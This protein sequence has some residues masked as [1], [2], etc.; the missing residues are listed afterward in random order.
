VTHAKLEIVQIVRNWGPVGGMETY[1]WSLSEELAKRNCSVTVICEKSH[2]KTSNSDIRVIEIGQLKQKPRWLLYWR[3]ANRVEEVVQSLRSSQCIVV[4]SHERSIS[5]DI[6][7]FHSMPFA[8]VKD[9][10]WWKLLS[11]RVWVYLK[12]EKQELGGFSHQN[13]RIIPV[14]MVIAKIIKKYYPAVVS[15]IKPA[16]TPGVRSMPTKSNRPTPQDGG[17]IGFIGK[18]WRR[19]GFALFI[20]IAEQLKIQRPHLK[21][22]VLGPEKEQVADLCKNFQGEISFQGWQSSDRFYQEL[23]LLIH[24]ASSEAYGM[25]IAE[26]MSCK[27]PVLVS[28]ACGAAADVSSAHGS[29]LSLNDSLDVWVKESSHWLNHSQILSSY[30]RTW[31]QV[32]EEY[33]EQYQQIYQAKSI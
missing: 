10:A 21:V 4:H 33:L 18:E 24:P 27:V 3:F 30:Q 26:A 8:I 31:G 23:D 9:K 16:I 12:L 22:L 1:V 6:T 19:K 2:K 7:T 5:H 11:I 15:A 17:T 29:V 25:V 28:D 32:A 20:K 13:V 14:S